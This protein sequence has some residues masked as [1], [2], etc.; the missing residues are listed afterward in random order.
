[1]QNGPFI[2]LYILDITGLLTLVYE[3]VNSV[4]VAVFIYNFDNL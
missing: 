3:H 2:V 1:M 4:S